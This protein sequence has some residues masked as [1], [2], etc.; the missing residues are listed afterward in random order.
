MNETKK[1]FEERLLNT[2]NKVAAMIYEKSQTMPEKITKQ[3]AWEMAKT[4][5]F[6]SFNSAIDS[7]NEVKRKQDNMIIC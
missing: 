4:L 7:S 3:Q 5:T 6:K 2:C 1:Q